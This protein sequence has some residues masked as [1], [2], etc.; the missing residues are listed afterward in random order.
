M[1]FAEDRKGL[2]VEDINHEESEEEDVL[3]ELPRSGLVSST[4][5]QN[6]NTNHRRR[7][8]SRLRQILGNET[9]YEAIMNY[10]KL[11]KKNRMDALSAEEE[12]KASASRL[13]DSSN[14]THSNALANSDTESVASISSRNHS[15]VQNRLN[16]SILSMQR[17]TEREIIPKIE[18]LTAT[19]ASTVHFGREVESAFETAL[20]EA[21]Q[22]GDGTEKQQNHSTMD[23]YLLQSLCK[24]ICRK[25]GRDSLLQYVIE[26][27][28]SVEEQN[29]DDIDIVVSEETTSPQEE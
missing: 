13:Y 14:N 19:S 12:A 17:R 10:M 1:E 8:S 20:N 15:R 7:A 9:S 29:N 16:A 2:T 6:R 5:S 27:I 3:G 25:E 23:I 28:E 22:W 24:S 11:S 26:A 4:S 21:E 18:R